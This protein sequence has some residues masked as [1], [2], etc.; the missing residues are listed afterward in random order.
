[1]LVET[2]LPVYDES[3]QLL[4]TN[5]SRA[6]I[7]C[8]GGW[9]GPVPNSGKILYPQTEPDYV[10]DYYV[11]SFANKLYRLTGDTNYLHI[12]DEFAANAGLGGE[13][14]MQGLASFGAACRMLIH[15]I[16]PGQ[17][18][19]MRRMLVQMRT[20]AYPDSAMQL[21]AW[22]ID[23]QKVVFQYV[24]LDRGRAVLNNCEF[25]WV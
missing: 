17:P 9:G 14:I 7:L 13:I 4:C 5:I 21:R 18:E 12:D 6:S 20:P 23:A 16:I 1:M 8:E 3:G 22:K 15:A 19:R 25:E 11:P 24:D 10:M 2:T